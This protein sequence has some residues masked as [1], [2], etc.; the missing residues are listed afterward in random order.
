MFS[1]DKKQLIKIH[2]FCISYE[3][4]EGINVIDKTTS[5]KL[6]IENIEGVCLAIG[7]LSGGKLLIISLMNST[8][9]VFLKHTTSISSLKYSS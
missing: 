7:G 4:I 2:E 5:K 9:D 6:P 1:I 3:N 8:T